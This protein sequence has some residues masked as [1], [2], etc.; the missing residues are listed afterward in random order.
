MSV[1]TQGFGQGPGGSGSTIVRVVT[2]IDMEVEG[3]LAVEV[4]TPEIDVAILDEQFI[5]EG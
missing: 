1:L 2:E 5:L 4:V 3:N